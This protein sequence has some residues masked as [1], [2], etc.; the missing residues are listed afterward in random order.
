MT[1]PRM[2]NDVLYVMTLNV[3]AILTFRLLSQIKN[4]LSLSNIIHL[5]FSIIP[6]G[7]RVNVN[8]ARRRRVEEIFTGKSGIKEL[9]HNFDK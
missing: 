1:F 5:Y 4:D 6:S 9:I 2:N 7:V 3:S 8:E